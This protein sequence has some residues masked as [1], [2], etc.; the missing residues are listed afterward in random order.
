MSDSA[1]ED[2]S[3]A[4]NPHS[5]AVTEAQ[6]WQ[7]AVELAVL[8]LRDDTRIS[9]FSSQQIDSRFLV[10]AL[11]QLLTAEQSQQKALKASRTEKVV[12]TELTKARKKFV[13]DL[14]GIKDMRDGLVHFEDWSRGRGG[15]PQQERRA[16]GEPE[17][18]IAKA[19]SGFGY[20]PGEGTISNGPFSID[21]EKVDPAATD[22]MWAI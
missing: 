8:R 13:A 12:R 15:G 11:R 17:R 16:A 7:R 5:I 14:P 21:I 1:S 9:W 3:P 2:W 18:D 22:L 6:W 19:Y 20:D 4:D 10:I